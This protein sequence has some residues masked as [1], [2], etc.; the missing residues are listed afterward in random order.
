MIQKTTIIFLIVIIFC[1]TCISAAK[2]KILDSP[3]HSTETKP[4]PVTCGSIIKLKHKNTKTR[5]HSHEVTYGTG[6]GQQS[7]TGFPG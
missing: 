3:S 2:S 7:V 6:S 4:I 5:L 1:I